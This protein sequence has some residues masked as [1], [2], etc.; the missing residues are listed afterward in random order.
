MIDQTTLG[1][2]MASL[3]RKTLVLAVLLSLLWAAALFAQEQPEP[4]GPG[5]QPTEGEKEDDGQEQPPSRGE[6]RR[7]KMPADVDFTP[8]VEYGKGGEKALKLDIIQPKEKPE[9]PMPVLVFIHGGGWRGGNKNAGARKLV[10]FARRGYFCATIDYRL[11]NEAKFPAQI[12]DCKCA[13][14]FLRSKAKEYNLD[15]DRIGVWG[16]SAGGHLVALLGTSGG[17][18]ELEGKGGHEKFSSKVQAVCDWYG[19]ADLVKIVEGGSH[20]RAGNPVELLLGGPVEENKDKAKLASPVTHVDKD[21]P[22]FLIMH[23]DKDPLVPLS[24]SKLLNEKLKAVNVETELVVIEGAGHGGAKFLA[25]QINRKIADFFDKH[26]K[27]KA[28]GEKQEEPG[29]PAAPAPLAEPEQPEKEKEK[30]AGE[31]K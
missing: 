30:P 1:G 21:D 25:P 29:K 3:L 6:Q 14:R 15:P 28:K 10:P 22:P 11:S 23:G 31:G 17:V 8:D 2:N 7:P 18:K 9:K 5:Q 26:L 20:A 16:S 24:Q 4:A 19:P 12:E 27:R 13:I